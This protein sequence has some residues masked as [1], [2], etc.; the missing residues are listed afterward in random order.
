MRK[1]GVFPRDQCVTARLILPETRDAHVQ[2]I[3]VTEHTLT[4]LVVGDA[5]ASLTS[6]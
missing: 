4:G 5:V 6:R 2:A 3:H 1:A